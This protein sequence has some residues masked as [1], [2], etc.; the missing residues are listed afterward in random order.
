MAEAPT[1]GD[2]A[3]GLDTGLGLTSTALGIYTGLATRRKQKELARIGDKMRRRAY[4]YT[5]KQLGE[6]QGD[7]NR[8]AFSTKEDIQSDANDRGVLNSSIPMA[9]TNKV[10]EERARR[11]NT[12]QDR[13]DF[14]TH[15]Y[16]DEEQMRDIQKKLAKFQQNM[17]LVQAGIQGGAS[18]VGSFYSGV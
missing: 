12:L 1:A 15:N 10:E 9:A 11:Y 4:A 17:S 18:G 3:S 13:R 14:L 16:M 5:Q 6:A 7:V 8:R 2:Q